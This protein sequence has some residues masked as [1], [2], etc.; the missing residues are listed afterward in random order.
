EQALA[1]TIQVAQMIG[2]QSIGQNATQ[3][4][5]G[6]VRGRFATEYGVPTA[7]KL[8]DTKIAQARN[9]GVERLAVRQ[10]W[11]DLDARHDLQAGRR[12]GWRLDGLARF[13]VAT[14]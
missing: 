3:Q 13:A 4:M 1:L 5:Q 9:L 14:R 8:A 7:P 11:T 10:G 2:L 12:F 6:K